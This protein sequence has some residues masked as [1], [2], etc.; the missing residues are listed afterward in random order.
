[1]KKWRLAIIVG[2]FFVIFGLLFFLNLLAPARNFFWKLNEPLSLIGQATF[3]R[4]PSWIKNLF[5][6]RAIL[7]QNS[8]L[9]KENLNLQSELAK[10]SEVQYENEILKKELGFSQNEKRFNLIPAKIIGRSANGYFKSCVINKGANEGV[11]KGDAVVSQGFLVGVIGEVRQDN[12]DVTLITD[13]NSLIPV[14]LQQSRGTGLLRG[15]L[16]GL[17]IED[18]PLNTENIA[19]E[20][21]IT[22]GLGGLIP[23]GIA[24]GKT[25]KVVSKAG[26]IFQRIAVISPIDF[27]TLEILF[28]VE[29]HG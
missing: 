11:Q 15:G 8:N 23:D 28:V 2:S 7:R 16:Q 29:N 10:L 12:S 19:G 3:S 20:T 13:F 1:M 25:Q 6:I 26:E 21:V 27:S 17:V 14:V 5:R 9:V 24:V 18:V 4:T 22:S